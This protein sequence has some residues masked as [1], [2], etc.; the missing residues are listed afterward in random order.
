MHIC[1]CHMCGCIFVIWIHMIVV[2]YFASVWMHSSKM[3]PHR[4]R[5]YFAHTYNT[6]NIRF[7]ID[8]LQIL[9]FI[10]M[11]QYNLHSY[12]I[13]THVVFQAYARRRTCIYMNTHEQNL[14]FS[15]Y[16]IMKSH[17]TVPRPHT[18]WLFHSHYSTRTP[19]RTKRCSHGDHIITTLLRI[20]RL[21]YFD[22]FQ[23]TIRSCN[24]SAS[25]N[26]CRLHISTQHHTH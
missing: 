12:W 10:Q 8:A 5:Q 22:H 4:C 17:F 11:Y 6:N 15:T 1:Q 7:N 20:N 9:Y 25:L 23:N 24:R 13:Q 16:I 19:Y 21:H 18:W 3:H 14:V 2:W 26:Y